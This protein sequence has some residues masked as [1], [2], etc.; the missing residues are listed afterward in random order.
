MSLAHRS[1]SLDSAPTIVAPILLC[2]TQAAGRKRD[3][4]STIRA[5]DYMIKPAIIAPCGGE[6]SIVV[7]PLTTRTRSGTIRPAYRPSVPPANSFP[8]VDLQQCVERTSVGSS[9]IL[10][11]ITDKD[12]QLS[13]PTGQTR[14]QPEQVSRNLRVNV[15]AMEDMETDLDNDESDDELLLDRKGWNWDGRWE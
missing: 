2:N 11:I 1:H 7:A 3:R 14:G 8:K 12:K 4:A 9:A 10:P 15:E 13:E 5:S 6:T